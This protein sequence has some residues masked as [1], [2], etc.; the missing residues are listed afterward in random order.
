[1]R[2]ALL[3]VAAVVL[4][5]CS[6]PTVIQKTVTIEKDPSGQILKRIETESVTQQLGARIL[7]LEHI[8]IEIPRPMD[9]G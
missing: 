5:G 9:G 1:M 4:G 7:S 3:T 8:R 6:Y 2:Y